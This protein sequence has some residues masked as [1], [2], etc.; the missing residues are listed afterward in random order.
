ME[1]KAFEALVARCLATI[2]TEYLSRIDNLTFVIEEWASDEVLAEVGFDDPLDLLGDYLGIPLT[3]R[4]NDDVGQL[5]DVIV[6]YQGAIEAYA[7]DYGDPLERVIRE[8]L[9]HEIAHYFGFS[10]EEMDAIEA[11]WLEADG[12][13]VP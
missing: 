7:E 10:E 9:V 3:E 4:T 5:P 2:P 11:L 6:L 13:A 1:R 8:T 12:A